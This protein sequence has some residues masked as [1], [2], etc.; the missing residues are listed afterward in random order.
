MNKNV[1][2]L[3]G[4]AKQ[5]AVLSSQ[6]QFDHIDGGDDNLLNRIIWFSTM[7][8]KPY[9]KKMTLRIRDGE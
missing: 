9:P 3:T 4:K 6:P 1:G 8:G 7:N 2:E 5:L